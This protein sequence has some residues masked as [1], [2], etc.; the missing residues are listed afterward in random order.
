MS[1][2]TNMQLFD[3]DKLTESDS[4]VSQLAS[5]SGGT[6]LYELQQEQRGAH[7]LAQPGSRREITAVNFIIS[8]LDR[9]NFQRAERLDR[10]RCPRYFSLASSAY[11]LALHDGEAGSL[12]SSSF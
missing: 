8:C 1:L 9:V 11:R 2:V 4:G 5:G 6:M 10:S 3:L 7:G 12:N